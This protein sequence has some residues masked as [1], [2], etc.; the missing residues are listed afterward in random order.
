[1]IIISKSTS[2]RP[3]DWSPMKRD[4]DKLESAI[5]A[6]EILKIP[7]KD[8]PKMSLVQEIAAE[9]INSFLFAK[10]ENKKEAIYKKR[11]EGVGFSGDDEHYVIWVYYNGE[12][13]ELEGTMQEGIKKIKFFKNLIY[14][15]NLLPYYTQIGDLDFDYLQNREFYENKT[16]FDLI[17]YCTVTDLK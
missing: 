6:K 7:I 2:G 15:K 9:S 10:G 4:V 8:I 12:V 16:I 1:M 3:L 17:E 13:Y 11:I 14:P 5:F